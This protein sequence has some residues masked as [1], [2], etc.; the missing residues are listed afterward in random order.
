MRKTTS[1]RE[2]LSNKL[3][4]YCI[5]IS[6][7]LALITGLAYLGNQQ[8]KMLALQVYPLYY[9]LLQVRTDL[10]QN[11]TSLQVWLH[12]REN[13]A[14]GDLYYGINK[15]LPRD[16]VRTKLLLNKVDLDI[17]FTKFEKAY[18]VFRW[19]EWKI[20]DVRDLAMHSDFSFLYGGNLLKVYNK[21]NNNYI[22]GAKSASITNRN[23]YHLYAVFLR[24]SAKLN[25]YLIENY[26]VLSST[27][28]DDLSI[29]ETINRAIKPENEL[30]KSIQYLMSKYLVFAHRAIDLKSRSPIIILQQQMQKNFLP[31]QKI[32]LDILN[33]YIAKCNE[34][35]RNMQDNIYLLGVFTVAS[36][37]ILIMVSILVGFS[38]IRNLVLLIVSPLEKL[39][40]SMREIARGGTTIGIKHSKIKEIVRLV[41]SI[42]MMLQERKSYEIKLINEKEEVQYLAYHDLS[43]RVYNFQY[44]LK[45][46]GEEI[47]KVHNLRTQQKIAVVYYVIQNI[48]DIYN[49]L[50]QVK[51]ESFIREY[52]HGLSRVISGAQAFSSVRSHAFVSYFV[53]DN[54]LDFHRI[55][56]ELQQGV[57]TKSIDLE[58]DI[59]LKISVGISIYPDHEHDIFMLTDYARSSAVKAVN[60][61]E[62]LVVFN[63]K[64]KAKLNFK[65]NLRQDFAQAI[66]KKEFFLMFQPQYRLDNNQVIGC[67][68]LVRWQHPHY[69]LISPNE[70]IHLAEESNHI[71]ELGQ[72]V[73]EETIQQAV[74]WLPILPDGF[75]F[76]INASLIEILSSQYVET[77]IGLL[78][79]YRLDP[80]YIEIE[81]LESM[82]SEYF[83]LINDK[84]NKLHAY[85]ISVSLD[86]FGTGY[87]S[88]S[89]LKNLNFD[90][91]KID[92]SFLEGLQT[93]RNV[94]QLLQVI[95][96]LAQVYEI[97]TLVEG[98]ET[99]EDLDE[100]SKIGCTYGQGYF[101]SEPLVKE[102]MQEL[103]NKST[104]PNSSE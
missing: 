5:V 29:L 58:F 95:V 100:L 24:I 55:H 21:I 20:L 70:F 8:S 22:Y 11:S 72:Y 46:L 69:N 28:K 104:D 14:K 62:F 63:E 36:M 2:Y 64:D 59:D 79:T 73:Q 85:G 83:D 98:I 65:Y 6:I 40:I 19:S 3:I 67:E 43:L 52:S 92:K 34:K 53:F 90:L 57:D 48:D 54:K 76:A 84:I 99:Q 81:I 18:S 41:R 97:P 101:L 68:V 33:G 91:I 87:S 96:N 10:G 45:C 56:H 78:E 103:L 42:K 37:V 31:K 13:I 47:Q 60:N 50:G 26:L 38:F 49:S 9:Q 16:I 94:L 7:G 61:D 51:G 39:T 89:R 35:I 4:T 86:D 44:F 15:R 88:L 80:N 25:L 30:E 1:L 66:N 75:K 23:Y 71:I 102:E 12:T 77:L 17:D 93:S 82:A 32:L 27:I 74:K